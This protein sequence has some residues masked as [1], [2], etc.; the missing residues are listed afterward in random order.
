M[1]VQNLRGGR[2]VENHFIEGSERQKY[3]KGWSQRRKSERHKS[4]RRKERRKCNF[5]VKFLTF[6]F[7]L[8]CQKRSERQKS[9]LSDFQILMKWQ[10]HMA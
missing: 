7:Y 6:W 3:F 4:E 2:N 5:K 8:W 10:L 9:N 1:D